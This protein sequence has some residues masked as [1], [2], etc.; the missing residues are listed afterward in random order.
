MQ[1]VKDGKTASSDAHTGRISTNPD[2]MTHIYG[3]FKWVSTCND[4][5]GEWHR[6][7]ESFSLTYL[8]CWDA[9]RADAAHARAPSH[10][11]YHDDRTAI[12]REYRCYQC[13][14]QIRWNISHIYA[15]S[16]SYRRYPVR[17]S[18]VVHF[19]VSG[20]DLIV[21]KRFLLFKC[22]AHFPRSHPLRTRWTNCTS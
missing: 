14:D 10:I 2:H 20:V 22:T 7:S 11:R 16:S 8:S 12:H 21:K 13:K 3:I 17:C 15:D 1:W 4:T 5:E 19:P 6:T 9:P 18:C